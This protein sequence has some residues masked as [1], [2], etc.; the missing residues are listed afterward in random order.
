MG[1]DRQCSPA[2]SCRLYSGTCSRTARVLLPWRS[3]C[4]YCRTRPRWLLAHPGSCGAQGLPVP[5]APVAWVPAAGCAELRPP[6]RSTCRCQRRA[7]RGCCSRRGPRLCS[8]SWPCCTA[9]GTD[10]VGRWLE[11]LGWG[12]MCR[13]HVR[14]LQS[15]WRGAE[16]V[17]G[18]V[19]SMW[20][21]RHTHRGIDPAQGRCRVGAR[22]SSELPRVRG[23]RAHAWGV[24]VQSS[25]TGVQSRC[26]GVLSQGTAG[27]HRA[28]AG[29]SGLCPA[30]AGAHAAL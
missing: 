21:V 24:W 17:C 30:R 9:P 11:G 28:C 7:S 22:W 27:R 12:R 26:Q 20:G 23:C 14:W 25:G 5:G 2:L 15:L 1:R 4:R 18:G 6:H 19:H 3:W 16:P 13:A 29:C 8:A 10:C